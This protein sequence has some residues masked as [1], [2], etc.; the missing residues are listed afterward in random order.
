VLGRE[1]LGSGVGGGPPEPRHLTAVFMALLKSLPFLR[2]GDGRFEPAVQQY[3]DDLLRRE[4]PGDPTQTKERLFMRDAR[5]AKIKNRGKGLA[6]NKKEDLL[7]AIT[8]EYMWQASIGSIWRTGD[9]SAMSYPL[10]HL[11]AVRGFMLRNEPDDKHR[12]ARV[13][14]LMVVRNHVGHMKPV[15]PGRRRAMIDTL[16][17]VLRC[18]DPPISPDALAEVEALKETDGE[19]LTLAQIHEAIHDGFRLRHD[20]IEGKALY[21]CIPLRS[22]TPASLFSRTWSLSFT[23]DGDL[24]RPLGSTLGGSR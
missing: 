22:S 13:A 5:T 8:P 1:A 24:L 10:R 16:L 19:Q 15:T 4:V 20:Y 11:A 21:T 17:G 12:L 18:C 9:Y 14:G 2:D 3:W 6:L 23:K 7:R